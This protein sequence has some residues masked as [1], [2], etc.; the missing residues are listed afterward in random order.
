M[1]IS[2]QPPRRSLLDGGTLRFD[3]SFDPAATRPVDLGGP[4]GTIDTDGNTTTFAHG[5]GGTGALTKQ[6]AG[7]LILTGA[8]SYAGGTTIAAGTLQIGNGGT[9]GS[10]VGDI[11]NNAAWSSIDRTSSPTPARSA[12][13]DR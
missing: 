10:L 2:A 12:A 6:G 13:P 11:V 4:G 7:T 5:I 8:N 9:T 3:A 1:P